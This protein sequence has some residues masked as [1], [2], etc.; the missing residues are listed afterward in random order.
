MHWL[1]SLVV[2]V[3]NMFRR[4]RI[5]T[6]LSEQ[7]LA[8]REMIKADLMSR[9]M[10][11]V[12]A[13]M[14]SK[15]A[16]GNEQLVREF[17]RDQF[18]YRWL[19]N[20]ARDTRYAV[21]GLLRVPAF[22]L[23]VVL[24]L[25]LGIGM[26]TAI[27]S[28]V[29]RVLLRPLAFPD[30]DRIMLLHEQG[31]GPRAASAPNMDVNPENWLDWQRDSKTFESFA[32]WTNR[33]PATLTG[34][35]EPERLEA[36]TVSREFFSVLG[37]R[38]FLGR[39]FAAEDDRPGAAPTAIISY[40]LWQRKFA[41]AP[42]IIGKTIQ[43]NSRPVSVIGVMP[44]GF[45]FLSKD[46]QVWRAFGL[47]RGLAWRERGGRFL[48][49]VIGR[50]KADV[51]PAAA[52]VE[53]QNIAARLEQTYAFNK[54]TTVA[55]IPLREVVT[56]QV[57][58]SLL[59]LF[60]A[61]GVL[62]AIACSNVANLLVAR[63]ANR[64]RE[65]AIRT[66]LGAVRSE[67]IRQFLI[68]SLLL[69]AISGIAGVFVARWSLKVLLALAPANLLPLTEVTIDRSMLLYTAA[70]S[71]IT[72]VVV[73][74]LPAL[75]SARVAIA[76]CLRNGGRSVTASL[77]VRQTLIVAQ[78]AM[79]V[80][81]LSGAGLLVRSL[82]RLTGDPIGVKPENVLTMRVELPGSRYN[83]DR[84]VG[85]FQQATARLSS[86]TGVD[87]VSAAGDIPVS[88]Q[89][90]AGTGIQI[91][92]GESLP[93]TGGPFARVRVVMPGYFRTLGIPLV[94]GREFSEDD[95]RKDAPQTFVVNEAFVRAYFP[96]GDPL[97]NSVSVFMKRSNPSNPMYGDP[98][99]PFGRIIGVS[100]DVKEGTLRDRSEPTVF[101]NERQLTSN[102]M[103]F[104]VRSA[105][106]ADL[107]KEAGA[108]VRDMDR[109]LPLIEV[110]MLSDAFAETLARDRLN[111]TVSAAFA[112]CALLLAAVGLYGLLAFTV[113]ARTNEIGIRMALGAQAGQVLA[114]IVQQG[115]RL[116]LAG[117]FLG[118]IVAFVTSRV[119]A[120]LLFGITARDPLTFASVIAVLTLVTL[121][122]VIIPALRATRIDP[123]TALREE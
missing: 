109:N 107:A 117:G 114:M 17:S 3:L 102:G 50:V 87:S 103:T 12:E 71:L 104:L 23:G 78:V 89:R 120:S 27:F 74:L 58:S 69:A 59:I 77:W 106:G 108:L 21:R 86:L 41:G 7:L 121:I 95:M 96:A 46:T 35:G 30:P 105:R 22:T 24:T 66:S 93:L 40:T 67:I 116:V 62:L 54:N 42:D 98:D 110:R 111:A 63:S 11:A 8:H 72:G 85:F 45:H 79:T 82:L 52:K 64:R 51:S 91:L 33:N 101:Y 20:F 4:S 44:S 28:A 112:V 1:R 25:A 10:D 49:Y 19:D 56:G 26:N 65:I 38:P 83:E 14:A 73:G 115:Y 76:D 48:P 9:G 29:D 36:E 92:G 75:S 97:S 81:L 80:V 15:R 90:T 53:M 113:A 119:L 47:D 61:V 6:D 55:V 122:A 2:R 43:L 31:A 123:M 84:Q 99:N 57:R 100:G 94:Q 39:D 32:A 68:E 60:A 88:H 13:D 18:L 37:V 16:L 34:Q 70:L 118:L 5:E